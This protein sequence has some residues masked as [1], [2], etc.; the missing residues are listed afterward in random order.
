[1]TDATGTS[2]GGIS[3]CTANENVTFPVVMETP[4]RSDSLSF[5]GAA[6]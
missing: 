6:S 5:G 4:S 3:A 1:M 2:A